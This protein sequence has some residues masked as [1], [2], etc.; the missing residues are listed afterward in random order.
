MGKWILKMIWQFGDQLFYVIVGDQQAQTKQSSRKHLDNN[1][2]HSN[3]FHYFEQ[4]Y[5]LQKLD[6]KSGQSNGLRFL[7]ELYGSELCIERKD[8]LKGCL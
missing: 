4:I 5:Y 1:L 2:Q 8:I 6:V 3:I 7:H